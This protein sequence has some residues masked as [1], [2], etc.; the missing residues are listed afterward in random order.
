M[1]HPSNRATAKYAWVREWQA[2][3][4]KIEAEQRLRRIDTEILSIEGV[5][6]YLHCSLQ[7]ARTIPTNELPR[8]SGPGRRILFLKED[9]HAYLARRVRTR[10]SITPEMVHEAEQAMLTSSSDSG[11]RRPRKENRR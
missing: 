6:E 3:N 5:A 8:R 11:R 10:S 7:A 9:V 2:R 4:R 1:P